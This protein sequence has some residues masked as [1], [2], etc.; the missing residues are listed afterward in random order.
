MEPAEF[1]VKIIIIATLSVGIIG[2]VVESSQFEGM[3]RGQDSERLTI[4]LAHAA[5]AM[6]CLTEKVGGESRKG[7]LL[8]KELDRYEG[9]DACIELSA[10]WSVKVTDGEKEWR[11]GRTLTGRTSKKTLPVAIKRADGTVVPGTLTAEVEVII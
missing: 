9:R 6:P 1:L 2:M 8:E 7:T 4:D 3:V 5:S 10:A 11:M